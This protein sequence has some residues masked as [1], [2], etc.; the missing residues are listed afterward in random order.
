MSLYCNKQG[1]MWQDGRKLCH[2]CWWHLLL[3]SPRC[4]WCHTP[5]LV[6]CTSP[7]QA[8]GSNRI[9]AGTGNLHKITRCMIQPRHTSKYACV[10]M[11]CYNS[12][13]VCTTVTVTSHCAQLLW[14]CKMHYPTESTRACIS[15]NASLIH[16]RE[17]SCYLASSDIQA[18]HA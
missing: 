15:A 3:Q 5:I 9:Q 12:T 7:Y 16:T 10:S 14:K 8:E 1:C 4:G 11:V 13:T 18:T 6:A 17:K 2:M